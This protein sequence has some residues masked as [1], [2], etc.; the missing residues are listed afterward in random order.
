MN[1]GFRISTGNIIVYLNADDYFLP[2]AFRSVIPFFKKKE[3]FVVGNVILQ[4]SK[5]KKFTMKPNVTHEGMLRHWKPNAF[6]NNPLQYFYL[7]KIQEEITFNEENYI[8][9]DYE[10]LLEVSSKYKL[11]KIEKTL[12]VYPLLKNAKYVTAQRKDIFSYWSYNNFNYIDKYIIKMSKENIINFK[13]EQQEAYN[14]II[15]NNIY[16]RKML[17]KIKTYF[18]TQLLKIK[19]ALLVK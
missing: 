19:Y 18:K 7:R 11:C 3:I 8:T 5:N 4:I 13:N 17:N 2:G 6:P 16:R 12:G 15:K 1:K 14:K 10:F 9:M